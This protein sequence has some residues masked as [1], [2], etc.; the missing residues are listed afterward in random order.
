[1]EVRIQEVVVTCEERLYETEQQKEGEEID[2]EEEK[3]FQ[4]E[5]G[6]QKNEL[7]KREN[8]K[9]YQMKIDLKEDSIGISVRLPGSQIEVLVP[10]EELTC[11]DCFPHHQTS[12]SGPF[13]TPVHQYSVLDPISQAPHQTFPLASRIDAQSRVVVV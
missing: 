7:M 2:E 1:M 6:W 13:Q 11:A 9:K 10:E 12:L 3:I 5:I 4:A 8:L